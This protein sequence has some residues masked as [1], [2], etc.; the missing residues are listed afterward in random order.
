MKQSL[1][2]TTRATAVSA[3]ALAAACGRLD[4]GVVPDATV[5]ARCAN[6]VGHDEDGDGIDD[7]CDGCPHIYDPEQIDSDGDGVDDV[8]DPNPTIPTESIALFDPFTSLRP[9]WMLSGGATPTIVG[10]SAVIDALNSDSVMALSVVPATDYFEFGG[11]VGAA[12]P[13]N[14]KVEISVKGNQPGYYY[15][16]LFDFGGTNINF[17]FAYTLDGTNYATGP[18][19][20]LQAPLANAPFVLSLQHAPGSAVC[21]TKWPPGASD[22]DPI[23]QGLGEDSLELHVS[24]DQ[25]RVDYFSQ[26]PTHAP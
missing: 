13:P 8:C 7:A 6:A 3:L 9:I 25:V 12:Q 17:D 21:G 22:Q 24:S 26:I 11:S 14:V 1:V 2:V 18:I 4:F 16:E 10:D 20:Q 5:I 19:T 15:C 23:P